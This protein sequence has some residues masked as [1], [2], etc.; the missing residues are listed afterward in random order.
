MTKLT[1]AQR[2]P[3]HLFRRLAPPLPNHIDERLGSRPH[4]FTIHMAVTISFQGSALGTMYLS[5][6]PLSCYIPHNGHNEPG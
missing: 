6:S 1:L 2:E 4:H 5:I 3:R